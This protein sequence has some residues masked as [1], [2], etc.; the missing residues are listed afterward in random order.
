MG[1]T[2]FLRSFLLEK[3][4]SFVL[5]PEK[6]QNTYFVTLKKIYLIIL[7]SILLAM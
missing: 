2:C 4:L 3:P 1:K 7:I 5:K 6:K